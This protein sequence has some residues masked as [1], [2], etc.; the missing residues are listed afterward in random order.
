MGDQIISEI[1]KNYGPYGI[2]YAVLIYAIYK[3]V[4]RN[5]QL[6]D[7]Y[8][9][10]AG[11]LAKTIEQNTASRNTMNFTFEGLKRSIEEAVITTR[12]RPGRQHDNV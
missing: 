10:L 1:I 3:L 8:M 5:E 6:T 12:R 7:K 11:K 2:S 9:D 4:A